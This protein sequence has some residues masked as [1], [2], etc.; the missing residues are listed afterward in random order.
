MSWFKHIVLANVLEDNIVPRCSARIE[1]ASE[2]MVNMPEYRLFHRMVYN[3]TKNLNPS[4]VTKIEFQGSGSSDLDSFI[5][6][7]QHIELIKDSEAI[8]LLNM[9]LYKLF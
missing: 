3:I 8:R 7:S 6:K 5:G 4:R 9:I 2:K 1:E